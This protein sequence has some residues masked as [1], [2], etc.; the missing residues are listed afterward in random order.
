MI[1]FLAGKVLYSDDREV[2]IATPS[3]VGYQ[4]FFAGI[5]PEGMQA[6]IFVSEI[7]RETSQDLYGFLD[8]KDKKIFEALLSV[9]GVG[10]KSAFALVSSLDYFQI[11]E[12]ITLD[13]KKVLTKAP[14]IGAKAAAQIVLDLSSK[15]KNINRYGKHYQ[16]ECEGL[17]AQDIDFTLTADNEDVI[18]NNNPGYLKA[19]VLQDALLACQE[20]GFSEAKVLPLMNEILAKN[21]VERSEQLVH[22]V[23]RGI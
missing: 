18:D 11:V 6:Q 15:I 21:N 19:A 20:L 9:K 14:G 8:I 1:G 23:L 10:P 7:I 16:F 2:I 22:L 17:A 4:V 12:A 5:L 13:Q 3:G